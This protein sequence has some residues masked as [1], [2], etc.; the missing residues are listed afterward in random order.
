MDNDILKKFYNQLEHSKELHGREV[1]G[2]SKEGEVISRN[3]D[4]QDE[5]GCLLLHAPA[6]KE[7][8]ELTG[9]KTEEELFPYLAGKEVAIQG[10]LIIHID[11]HDCLVFFPNDI[12]K[13]QFQ[14]LKRELE[15]RELFLFTYVHPKEEKEYLNYEEVIDFAKTILQE[16]N[17]E[18]VKIKQKVK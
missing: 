2:I 5:N 6:I 16:K 14:Y 4:A 18:K 17:N 12:N 1:I 10:T 9:C 13:F 15:L 11:L 8:G 3:L 7:I